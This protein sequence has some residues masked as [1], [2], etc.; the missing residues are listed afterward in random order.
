MI[1][2]FRVGGWIILPGRTVHLQRSATRLRTFLYHRIHRF[3]RLPMSSGLDQ[4]VDFVESFVEANDPGDHQED[5]KPHW[6]WFV[7]DAQD[8]NDPVIQP[9]R[10][11]KLGDHQRP[12]RSSV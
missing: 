10:I 12:C 5:A 2:C 4:L 11:A 6:F 7:C 1:A 3:G 8:S 9:F